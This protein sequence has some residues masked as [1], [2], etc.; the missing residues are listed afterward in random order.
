MPRL[1]Q[2]KLGAKVLSYRPPFILTLASLV[3]SMPE[4]QKRLAGVP[5][6]SASVL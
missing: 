5:A 1:L 3:K 6:L 4:A 2:S